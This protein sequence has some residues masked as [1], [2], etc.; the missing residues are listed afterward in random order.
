MQ[1]RS[2][3]AETESWNQT[4]KGYSHPVVL[5]GIPMVPG[6]TFG[7]ST[8]TLSRENDTGRI[9]FDAPFHGTCGADVR[10]DRRAAAKAEANW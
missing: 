6:N 3:S 1:R 8:G 10:Y 7:G 9:E 5:A 4:L 2:A